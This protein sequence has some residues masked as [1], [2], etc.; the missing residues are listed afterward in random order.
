MNVLLKTIVPKLLNR[1]GYQLIKINNEKTKR[2]RLSNTMAD[3]LVQI[4]KMGFQPKT[5]IDVGVACGTFPLYEA[6]PRAFHLLIEP[7]KEYSD[8]IEC[9]LNKY[10]GC[11]VLAAASSM[12]GK[13]ELNVHTEH[14]QGS[15]LLKEQMGAEFDG[16]PR[17]VNS[18]KIDTLVKEQNLKAPYLLKVDVQ[19]AELGVLEGAQ[20]TLQETEVVFLEVSMFEFMKGAPQFFDVVLYMKKHG[21]VAYDLYGGSNRP[22]DGALG[23]IDMVYVKENG[24]FRTNHSYA[25]P[26]QWKKITSS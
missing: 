19:G 11:F 25:T 3:V 20:Q 18:V 7:L 6:F 4:S 5:V 23:Q 21:F 10:E 12:D 9:I 15:S 14:L 2:T 1:F 8:S 26:N 24:M 17:M 16:V 13:I 22:L